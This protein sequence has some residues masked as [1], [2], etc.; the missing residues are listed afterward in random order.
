MVIQHNLAALN[1]N[2]RFNITAKKQSK[3]TAKLSSGYKIN[4]AADDAAGLSIS[5]KMR[6]QIRGL[7]QASQNAQ[8]GISMVQIA[9]GA[10]AEIQDMLQRGSELSIKAA[11]GTLKEEDRAYIQ[12]EI[13]QLKKEINGIAQRTDFNDIKVLQSDLITPEYGLEDKEIILI[14]GEMPDW[15]TLGSKDNLNEEYKTTEK[16]ETVDANGNPLIEDVEITHEAATIDFS[17]F[18]GSAEK[19]KELVGNGFYTTCCTCMAHYSIRF[20]DDTTNSVD[21]SGRHYIYNIGIGDA[22]DAQDLLNRIIAGTNN[23][24]P[25][26]HY[27]KLA[28]DSAAK[29]LIVYDDRCNKDNPKAG[30]AGTWKDW[31]NPQF[32]IKAGGE[33]G[34][35]GPGTVYSMGDYYEVVEIGQITKL[36][37]IGLQLGAD[38]G[39]HMDIQ[40]PLIS[41]G[42]LGIAGVNVSTLEGADDGIN[43]FKKALGYVSE[44]RS[45]M[46]AYQ[47]RL[48]HT[49]RNLD[50]ITENTTASESAIRDSDIAQMMMEFTNN[51]I[52]MQA[53]QAMLSQANQN[54]QMVLSL[55]G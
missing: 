3:T 9:D 48:E 4:R 43:A 51:N 22:T 15:T 21:R 38:P 2:R 6:R 45:R 16:F 10:M 23:G 8:D 30:V 26:G 35:F 49:I 36:N 7:T 52:I 37:V 19:I 34:R 14:K 32:D 11:N 42:V 55:L 39:Q 29:K 44:Q 25:N 17:Q 47:N 27:T 40:L 24:Y 50:N 53:A 13:A 33:D 18:D 31:D 41:C 5:E 46:G 28:V 20:T 12:M 1:A 54:S